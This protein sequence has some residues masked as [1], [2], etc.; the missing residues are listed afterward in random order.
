MLHRFVLLVFFLLSLKG[1]DH[2]IACFICKYQES[3]YIEKHQTAQISMNPQNGYLLYLRHFAQNRRFCRTCSV[4]LKIADLL[5]PFKVVQHHM[6]LH[7]LLPI[8]LPKCNRFC[9]E[10]NTNCALTCAEIIILCNDKGC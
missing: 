7:H 10:N 9:M 8:H 4:L 6:T 3:Q 5:W 2:F 1:T